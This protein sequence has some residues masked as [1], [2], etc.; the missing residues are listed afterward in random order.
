MAKKQGAAQ[1]LAELVRS[2]Q[3]D[4]SRS[5]AG[6]ELDVERFC[7]QIGLQVQF[8]AGA[9]HWEICAPA[10]TAQH[11]IQLDVPLVEAT[12]RAEQELSKLSE[13][14]D[15]TAL[16]S[17]SESE[18]LE[19]T[20]RLE[21]EKLEEGLEAEVPKAKTRKKKVTSKTK[22]KAKAKTK[23]KAKVQKKAAKKKVVMSKAKSKPKPKRR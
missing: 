10:N 4:V 2:L 16:G 17:A 15:P 1:Q 3:R 18:Q 21:L 7:L 12:W 5:V 19:H 11:F 20:L 14:S 9:V 13:P 8:K 23:T 6:S 22:T